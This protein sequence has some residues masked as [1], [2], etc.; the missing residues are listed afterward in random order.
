MTAED[1]ASVRVPATIANVGPGFDTF[2][3]AIGLH[4]IYTAERAPQWS[5]VT[6]GVD[7]AEVPSDEQNLVIR[8]ME[9]ASDVLGV[10]LR[11]R[12]FANRGIPLG[13][14]LGS[15]AAAIVGG[16][17]LVARL[18][19]V[20]MSAADVLDIAVGIEGHADNVAAALLG[21]FVVA[22]EHRGRWR[23]H[24][25]EPQCGIAC[26][27]ALSDRGVQTRAARRALAETVTRS[28]AVFNLSH[29]ALMVAGFMSGSVELVR[30]SAA[31]RIH[32]RSRMKLIDDGEQVADCIRD[33]TEHPVVLAGSG[34]TL[35][36]IVCDENDDAA[37]GQARDLAAS[38]AT[39]CRF[40][41]RTF[42]PVRIERCGA[43]DVPV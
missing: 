17:L 12:V 10:S 21:G 29:A 36:V 41:S 35:A 33:H 23:A 2:G 28:D 38:L 3:L 25:V 30:A 9:A 1:S 13:R 20:R 18:A 43:I 32:E 11:A 7:A 37:L 26:V 24:R 16:I 42:E 5:V 34:P 15:S 4:D 22:Y 27:L 14:G 19:G 8:A 31:D 6:T 40:A 39:A